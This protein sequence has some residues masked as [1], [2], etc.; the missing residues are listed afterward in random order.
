MSVRLPSAFPGN[1]DLAHQV[2]GRLCSPYSTVSTLPVRLLA[3]ERWGFHSYCRSNLPSP[4]YHHGQPGICP[5]LAPLKIHWSRHAFL[6][7]TALPCLRMHQLASQ[8]LDLLKTSST[9]ASGPCTGPRCT[10]S[11]SAWSGDI[12]ERDSSFAHRLPQFL[13]PVF[14]PYPTHTIKH[15]GR[16]RGDQGGEVRD[17]I[18]LQLHV[19]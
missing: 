1:M 14:I 18:A 8:R 4:T 16:P 12:W 10:A 5:P 19:F 9:R 15:Y 6:R 2:H 3:V 7:V 13:P 11:I 17:S